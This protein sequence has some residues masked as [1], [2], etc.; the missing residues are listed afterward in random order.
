MTEADGKVLDTWRLHCGHPG[1]SQPV[2]FPTPSRKSH[3]SAG[4]RIQSSRIITVSLVSKE[5]A[6]LQS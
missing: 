6:P 1:R 3:E 2:V 4:Q 5:P